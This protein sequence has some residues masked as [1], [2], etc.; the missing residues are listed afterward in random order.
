MLLQGHHNW[1][2]R[3]TRINAILPA[4]LCAA[5]CARR[6]GPARAWSKGP[7]S[8]STRGARP[9]GHSGAVC[10]GQR[11]FAYDMQRGCNGVWYATGIF[12]GE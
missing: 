3:F 11:V 10:S 5:R 1:E 8:A 7:S 4:G 2:T 12:G 6:V 9:S